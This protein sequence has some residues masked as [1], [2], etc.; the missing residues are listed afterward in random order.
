MLFQEKKRKEK[1]TELICKRCKRKIL[2]DFEEYL[3]K[4]PNE[5]YIECCYCFWRMELK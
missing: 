5:K 3:I 2:E 1:M 4:Y